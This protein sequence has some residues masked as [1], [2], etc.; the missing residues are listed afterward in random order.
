VAA[1]L[2]L[3][4]SLV[5]NVAGPDV[6]TLRRLTELIA[7]RVGRQPQFEERPPEVNRDLVA[8]TGLMNQLLITARERI[9]E[10]IAEVCEEAMAAQL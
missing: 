6:L 5:V 4:G 9:H 1:S 7:E 8:D 3:D 2:A 10:R